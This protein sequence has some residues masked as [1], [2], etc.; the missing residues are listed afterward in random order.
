MGGVAVPRPAAGHGEGDGEDDERSAG[1]AGEGTGADG[2]WQL[3]GDGAAA[4]QREVSPVVVL[5]RSTRVCTR[6]EC[7]SLGDG[8]QRIHSS[9][10]GTEGVDSQEVGELWWPHLGALL[11]ADTG[12]E[13]AGSGSNRGILGIIIQRIRLVDLACG[14]RHAHCILHLAV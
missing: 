12:S 2:D 9:A 5:Q 4:L 7:S 14:F 8:K 13:A 1:S 3:V 6:R 10:A 11:F